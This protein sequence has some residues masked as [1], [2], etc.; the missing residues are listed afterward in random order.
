MK[1][2]SNLEVIDG[3]RVKARPSDYLKALSAAE[4]KAAVT[5]FLARAENEVINNEDPQAKAE[6]E[7]DVATATEYLQ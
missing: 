4:Q 5:E 2:L 6:A 1:L 3:N 7:I